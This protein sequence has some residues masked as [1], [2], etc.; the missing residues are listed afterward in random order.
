M[1]QAK[2]SK[3]G[4]KIGLLC[5]CIINNIHT[6]QPIKDIRKNEVLAMGERIG[7]KGC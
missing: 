2:K 3:M 4:M 5:F 7:K 1:L 6:T